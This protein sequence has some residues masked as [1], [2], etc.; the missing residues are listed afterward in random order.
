MLF[1]FLPLLLVS[2]FCS[3]ASAA[4]YRLTVVNTV[5]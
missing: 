2:G 3:T 5:S 4:L 1:K